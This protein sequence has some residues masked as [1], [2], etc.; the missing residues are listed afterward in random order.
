MVRLHRR[1][2]RKQGDQR[3]GPGAAEPAESGVRKRGSIC[4]HVFD[5]EQE[6]GR[7]IQYRADAE[8]TSVRDYATTHFESPAMHCEKLPALKE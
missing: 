3:G 1:R 4:F 6:F 2:D 5:W 8:L 7:A